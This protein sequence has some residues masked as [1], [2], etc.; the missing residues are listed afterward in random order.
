MTPIAWILFATNMVAIAYAYF[1]NEMWF[2]KSRQQLDDWFEL[3]VS[4]GEEWAALCR[5]Q[6]LALDAA[7]KELEELRN[8]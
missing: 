5:K 1:L 2:K 6:Q 3:S 4:Q 8:K 7:A